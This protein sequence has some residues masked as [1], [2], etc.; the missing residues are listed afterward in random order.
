[1]APLT[2]MTGAKPELRKSAAQRRAA[3]HA[4]DPAAAAGRLRDHGMA[5][6]GR[7]SFAVFSG[8]WPIRS[9]I[10]PRPLMLGLAESGRLCCLP[11]VIGPGVLQFRAWDHR[12]ALVDGPLGT[13]HPSETGAVALPDL[14]LVPLLAF[15]RRRQR[16]GYGAGHYDATLT[17][18]RAEKPVLAV[19]VAYAAQ[20][21]PEVPTDPWDQPLDLIL[22]EAEII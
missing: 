9:E 17:A 15:D 3:A 4:L 12:E 21:V 14:L 2:A 22:T 20:E 5:A 8:Y 19:G 16:L 11:A 10:D 13:S 1:M 7:Y 6:L 18:L